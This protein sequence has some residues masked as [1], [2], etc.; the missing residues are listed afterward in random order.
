MLPTATPP[1]AFRETRWS[2]VARAASS[3]E[4]AARAA[5]EELCRLY[6]QPLH[7]FAV[8]MGLSAPDAED[9]TQ[10]FLAEFL[11]RERF[12]IA[13]PQRGRLRTFLCTAFANHLH[14]LHRRHSAQRRGGGQS[15]VSIHPP[16]GDGALPLELAD[17]HDPMREFTRAWALVTMDAAVARLEA[18]LDARGDSG[19]LAPYRR[20]LGLDAGDGGDYAATARELGVGEGAVRVKVCR[21]RREFRT[22]LFAVIADTLDEPTEEKIRAEVR[23]LIEALGP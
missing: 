7:A 6:W 10:S 11:R 3:A 9:A 2:L 12:A 18:A 17:P 15:H 23:A 22:A 13:D 14:D 20:F 19:A 21:L 8:R 4:P 5:L 1:S 16:D